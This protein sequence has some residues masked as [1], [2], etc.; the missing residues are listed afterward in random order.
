DEARLA[1]AM[2]FFEEL[3]C[4]VAID[5]FGA[6]HSNFE[7]VW[8]IAPGIVKLDRVLAQASQDPPM[9]RM[10]AHMVSMLHE[11]GC[12]V[13]LEG[14]ET[15]AQLLAAME[16]DVD[17]VQGYYLGE[18]RPGLGAA[19]DRSTA[20]DPPIARF[21]GEALARARRDGELVD[22]HRGDVEACARCLQ[23][24]EPPRRPA[25]HCSASS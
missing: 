18:P 6:G 4:V 13:V 24:G 5:D 8:R 20:L 7:R 2:R 14:I 23:A 25:L 16:A 12:F 22:A 9:R 15:E 10:L 17:F 11:L 19:A 3:G 1:R 21:R